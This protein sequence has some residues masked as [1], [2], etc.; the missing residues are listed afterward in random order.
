MSGL[1]WTEGGGGRD[2]TF[3]CF[4]PLE[5]VDVAIDACMVDSGSL[6]NVVCLESNELMLA[7]LLK[8]VPDQCFLDTTQAPPLP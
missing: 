3:T 6:T 8:L 2:G 5:L 4:A 7:L 1:S